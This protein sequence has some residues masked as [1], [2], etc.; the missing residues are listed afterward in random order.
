MPTAFCLL[1]SAFCLPPSA[2]R[3][4]PTAF[5]LPPSAF[6]LLSSNVPAREFRLNIT[7][8]KSLRLLFLLQNRIEVT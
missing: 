3:L 4:L 8:Q 7:L 6:Y 2:F 5:C 1:P